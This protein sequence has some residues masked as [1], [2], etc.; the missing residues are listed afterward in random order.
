MIFYFH[1]LLSFHICSALPMDTDSLSIM[2]TFP[3]HIRHR[4]SA[5][6]LPSHILIVWCGLLR[7]VFFPLHGV[8]GWGRLG[9]PRNKQKV[10]L[11][12]TEKNQ[13]YMFR[14]FFGY[15][16]L[17]RSAFRYSLFSS[18]ATVIRLQCGKPVPK[19]S[20]TFWALCAEWVMPW[21]AWTVVY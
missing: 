7:L 12:W 10:F 1:S 6:L 8:D 18:Y 13:K 11:V 17:S 5:D 2:A 16:I 15:Q 20:F 3:T 4:P 9:C 19:S 14:L 21:H